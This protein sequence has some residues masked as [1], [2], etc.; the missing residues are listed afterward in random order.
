MSQL[1]SVI[2]F[3][4]ADASDRLHPAILDALLKVIGFPQELRGPLTA[5]W[6]SQERLVSY[7]DEAAPHSLQTNA[8]TP[9]GD[10]F[11]P[12]MIWPS[13]WLPLCVRWF[14]MRS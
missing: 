10:P 5:V 3:Q 7:Y 11:G 13:S 9:Q 12:L 14:L 8:A 6:C 2:A 4:V 1:G